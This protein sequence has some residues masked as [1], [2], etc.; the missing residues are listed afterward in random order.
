MT[1]YY[2]YALCYPDGEYFYI[3]KGKNNR[4]IRHLKYSVHNDHVKHVI[5]KLRSRSEEPVVKRLLEH[6][7]NE[8]A[9]EEEKRLIAAY[10]MRVDGGLLCNLHPGGQGGRPSEVWSEESK[11]KLRAH[12]L[13]MKWSEESKAKMSDTMKGNTRLLGHVHSEETRQKISEASK[14]RKL[15]EEARKN[16]SE[17]KKGEKN[18][19]YGTVSPRR[20]IVVS[21]ETRAKL[22]AAAKRRNKHAD[23]S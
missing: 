21:S 15:S 6:I 19:M 14:G 7:S 2:V 5:A 12:R 8:E 20:G 18:P 13:G 10:G 17:A 3:G 22:S 11:A 23:Q 9:C 4:D 1:D 16:I